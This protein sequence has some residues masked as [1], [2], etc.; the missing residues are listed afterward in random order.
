MLAYRI[1][2]H[3]LQ[4]YRYLQK[5]PAVRFLQQR[6]RFIQAHELPDHFSFAIYLRKCKQHSFMTLVTVPTHTWA[7]LGFITTLGENGM[8]SL[9]TGTCGAGYACYITYHR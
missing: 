7:V 6:R 5:L 2:S 9:A 4:T 3:P 1:L 8:R